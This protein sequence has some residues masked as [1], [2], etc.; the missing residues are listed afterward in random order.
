[1]AS[2]TRTGPS[3]LM[4]LPFVPDVASTTPGTSAVTELRVFRSREVRLAIVITAVANMGLLMVFTYFAP[5]LTDVSGFA[6]G[7]VAVLLVVYGVGAAVGNSV[8]GWL[9]DRAL[10]PSQVGLLGLLTA[11]LLAAWAVS[12]STAAAAVMVFLVGALGFSVIPGMQT[13]V[14]NTASS[15]PTLAIAVNA[16]AY[17]VAAALAG[18]LGGLV[19]DG[20]GLRPVY[21]AAAAVTVCGI[22]VSCYAWHR[23]RTSV[24]AASR[25]KTEETSPA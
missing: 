22:L 2:T 21:L 13:R 4:V 10:M 20:P 17:Q 11:A 3:L 7:A 8:G 18:W 6:D 14:L 5:L 12:D 16:S 9:S 1:M 24:A 25:H 23:D 15:A 19:I